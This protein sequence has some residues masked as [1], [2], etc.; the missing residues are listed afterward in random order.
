LAGPHSSGTRGNIYAR[1]DVN[2]LE[3]IN[4]GGDVIFGALSSSVQGFVDLNPR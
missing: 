4:L 1:T 3:E 2:E